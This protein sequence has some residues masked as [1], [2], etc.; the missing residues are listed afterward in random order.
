MESK[1][2][3]D[4]VERGRALRRQIK[5]GCDGKC[6]VGE[7]LCKKRLRRKAPYGYVYV[8]ENKLN[9]LAWLLKIYNKAYTKDFSYNFEIGRAGD[10]IESAETAALKAVINYLKRD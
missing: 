7:C 9:N 2:L 5:A 10:A 6:A 8:K 4:A 3:M 1:F